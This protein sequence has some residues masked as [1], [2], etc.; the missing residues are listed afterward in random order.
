MVSVY[1]LLCLA[2]LSPHECTNDTAIDVMRRPM[3]TVN[4]LVYGTAR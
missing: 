4:W 3:T 1:A 2:S